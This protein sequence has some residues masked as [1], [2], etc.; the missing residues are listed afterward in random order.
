MSYTEVPGVRVPIR[1]WTDPATVES[2]AM[3]QLR[4]ISTL[5]WLHGLAVMPD[6]HLG[7]GRR[8]AP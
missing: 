5:P 6:V 7:K 2:Q 1:M 3:D 8:S 4:N